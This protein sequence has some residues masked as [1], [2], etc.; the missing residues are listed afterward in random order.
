MKQTD[1]PT[2][3]VAELFPNGSFPEGQGRWCLKFGLFA[4]CQ[5]VSQRLWVAA[6]L[7]LWFPHMPQCEWQ[8]NCPKTTFT[9]YGVRRYYVRRKNGKGTIRL[10]G[11]KRITSIFSMSHS[12]HNLQEARAIDRA[13]LDMYNEIRQAAEAHRQTR[14]FMQKWIRKGWGIILVNSVILLQ[15]KWSWQ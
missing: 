4:I 11:K 14:Q 15:I 8:R 2:R 1:P 3:P 10:R 5:R 7:Q 9:D 6:S 12:I 13:Q